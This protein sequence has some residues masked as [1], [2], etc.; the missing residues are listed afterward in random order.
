M[1]TSLKFFFHIIRGQDLLH[2]AIHVQAAG[3]VGGIGFVPLG[4]HIPLH[5]EFVIVQPPGIGADA[6]K[7]G[8]A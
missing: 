4:E 7:G 5:V 6:V 2:H 8:A 3:I 1:R